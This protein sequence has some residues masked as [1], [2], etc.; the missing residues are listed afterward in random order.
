MKKIEET[1]LRK[2]ISMLAKWLPK[3]EEEM[4]ALYQADSSL[5]ALEEMDGYVYCL[6]TYRDKVGSNQIILLVY[7]GDVVI[8]DLSGVH[9]QMQ[10][11]M[12]SEA[13]YE[14]LST[15]SDWMYLEH[16]TLCN[17]LYPDLPYPYCQEEEKVDLEGEVML[18]RNAYVTRA[19]RRQGIFTQMLQMVKDWILQDLSGTVTYCS[20]I[21]LDMDIACYGPDTSEE[22]YVYQYDVDEPIRMV[23]KEILESLGYYCVRLEEDE[24]GDGTKCWF[25]VKKESDIIIDTTLS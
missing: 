12:C 22:P 4:L 25:A 16:Y 8:A 19:Y 1:Y 14:D 20:C 18:F 13:V 5:Y 6:F 10:N 3:S 23:N 15:E 11:I 7:E 9:N 17:L 24:P 21:S 2:S